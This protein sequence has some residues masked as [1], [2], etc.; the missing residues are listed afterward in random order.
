NRRAYKPT[1]P[2]PFTL[3]AVPVLS[4]CAQC[5]RRHV[6]SISRERGRL[7]FSTHVLFKMTLPTRVIDVDSTPRLHISGDG[8]VGRWVALSYC[9]GGD[10]T[11]TLNSTSFNNLPTGLPLLDFPLTLRDAVLVTR[12]LGVRYLWIDSLCIFQDDKD[13]WAVEA[14]RMSD[15]Y[16]HAVVTIAA[17]SAE[18]VNDGF[19]G[20]RK[21]YF[22]CAFPWR[23]HD[24]VNSRPVLLRI[25]CDYFSDQTKQLNSRWAYRG[26]TF[27]EELLSQRLLCYMTERMIWYCRKGRAVEP[28]EDPGKAVSLFSTLKKLPKHSTGAVHKTWYEVLEKYT[29]RDLTFEKDRLPAIGAFSTSFRAMLRDQYSGVPKVLQRHATRVD[30]RNRVSCHLHLQSSTTFYYDVQFT[31]FWDHNIWKSSGKTT[32]Q[33]RASCSYY[34]GRTS[35]REKE[36]S[37]DAFWGYDSHNQPS[38]STA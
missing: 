31:V 38:A 6:L 12:A 21:A 22:S 14:S 16:S 27:Q 9:W 2:P 25:P 30:D 29:K 28:E 20:R 1:T 4:I 35:W 32:N 15:V 5:Y 7:Y 3:G 8:E 34:C 24:N 19:L 13:D 33:S 37:R 36:C 18:S 17:T 11:F 10:S 23:R 26:W